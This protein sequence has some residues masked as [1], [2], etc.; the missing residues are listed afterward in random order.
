MDKISNTKKDSQVTNNRQH[1]P[2]YPNWTGQTCVR[3]VFSDPR[4]NY[5]LYDNMEVFMKIN[6]LAGVSADTDMNTTV[7]VSIS[8][9][10]FVVVVSATFTKILLPRLRLLLLLFLFFCRCCYYYN[11]YNYYY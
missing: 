10:V 7:V 11:Y 2:P 6:L 3:T 9:L 8:F 5:Y 1:G 4:P